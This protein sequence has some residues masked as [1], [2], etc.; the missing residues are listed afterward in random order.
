M[1][2]SSIQWIFFFQFINLRFYHQA[3]EVQR[4]W[5]LHNVL[6]SV[7]Y[8]AEETKEMINLLED[9]FVCPNFFRHDDVS[10]K[11][12]TPVSL[13][14]PFFDCEPPDLGDFSFPGKALPGFPVQLER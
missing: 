13:P 3:A 1:F 6:L 10:E 5:N 8:A 14:F 12:V 2:Q 7:D 11:I 9:G 4:V